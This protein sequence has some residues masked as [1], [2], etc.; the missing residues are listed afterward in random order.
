MVT[1]SFPVSSGMVWALASGRF[2]STP[3]CN[4]GAVTMKMISN[5]SMTST[6]GVTLISARAPPPSCCPLE[7]MAIR[8][9]SG[10]RC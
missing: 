4:I 5:T 7:L 3:V 1:I 10:E 2:T 8:R 6:S 9:T